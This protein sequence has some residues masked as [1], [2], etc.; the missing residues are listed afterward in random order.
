MHLE[1]KRKLSRYLL[2]TQIL[3]Y[4]FIFLSFISYE[5][6]IYYS[7]YTA[8]IVLVMGVGLMLFL[9]NIVY[10][11]NFTLFVQ[12]LKNNLFVHALA[13]SLL[14][15]SCVAS[16]KYG[17]ISGGGIISVVLT[18]LSFYVFYLFIPGVIIKNIDKT[19]KYLL[20]RHGQAKLPKT[21]LSMKR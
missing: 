7:L 1:K 15:S 6:S 9:L 14:L 2:I 19:L 10:K 12:L 11:R 4:L 13:L 17:L 3:I 5:V 21:L 8:V 16:F 20:L 18:I